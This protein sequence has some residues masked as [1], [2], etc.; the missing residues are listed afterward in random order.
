MQFFRIVGAFV[1]VGLLL[2]IGSGCSSRHQDPAPDVD[3][4]KCYRAG[5]DATFASYA[6]TNH[7][8]C[9]RQISEL[10][11][12]YLQARIDSTPAMID[13]I[14]AALTWMNAGYEAAQG[15]TDLSHQWD[16]YQKWDRA[17]I[18]RK[19]QLDSLYGAIRRQAADGDSFEAQN[20]I[21]EALKGLGRDYLD[22]GDTT[23][24]ASL[25]G[26][27]GQIQYN[28]QQPGSARKYLQLGNE[29]SQEAGRLDF[30]ADCLL[31]L[32][33]LAS[34]HQADFQQAEMYLG[35]ALRNFRQLG[36]H[37]RAIFIQ[38][39]RAY[40]Q[41]QTCRYDR[42]TTYARSALSEA[43]QFGD[44]RSELW[45]THLLAELYLD[46]SLLDSA[47]AFAE[48][49]RQLREEQ[50]RQESTERRL[51]DL[52]HTEST[53]AL[54]LDRQG[55][56]DQALE[57]HEQS[58][59]LFTQANDSSG[60]GLALGRQ[61]WSHLRGGRFVAAETNFARN[62]AVATKFE[63]RL[64]AI[65]GLAVSAYLQDDLDLAQHHLERGLAQ[66]EHARSL[67]SLAELRAGILADKVEL[68]DLQALIHF[69][70]Y[71][72]GGRP[73]QLDSALTIIE[74]RQARTLAESLSGPPPAVNP[75][76]SALLDSLSRIHG[77]LALVSENNEV[78]EAIA[79][80]LQDS[81]MQLRLADSSAARSSRGEIRVGLPMG[82][83]SEILGEHG[84]M[85]AYVLSDWGGFVV[86]AETDSMTALALPMPY[87]SIRTMG[88]RYHAAISR[89]PQVAGFES[90]LD[91]SLA[92]QLRQALVPD[93]LMERFADRH[94]TILPTKILHHLPF[95]TL[96]D[97]DGSYLAESM[98]ISYA[99]S[100]AA[101]LAIRKSEP[102]GKQGSTVV[103]MGDPE[104]GRESGIAGLEFAA[105][106][107]L[108]VSEVLGP[109]HVISITK[110]EAC[111]ER[112]KTIDFTD[113][114]GWHLATHGISDPGDASRSAILLSATENDPGSGWLRGYEISQM[115]LPIDFAFLSA[116]ESG[117][118]EYLPGEGVLSL[119]RSFLLAGCRAVVITG[120]KVDDRASVGFVR[121]FYESLHKGAT[122]ATSLTMAQREYINSARPLYRHPYFWATYRVVGVGF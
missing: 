59:R 66:V 39:Q 65:Y 28:W 1:V 8:P 48:K 86:V 80:N 4:L 98:A 77:R 2:A 30:Q 18:V 78:L 75:D 29:L 36:N 82:W 47:Y 41:Q 58:C 62:L 112:L 57:R 115:H 21:A 16:K 52:A 113:V 81:L 72:A 64:N 51:S 107:I 108:C 68:Y 37:R 22:L 93:R 87:D 42:A 25:F 106:E 83:R 100:V 111:R 118:G 7:W 110:G 61:A 88:Q 35:Q 33:H 103:A 26:Y 122:V 34:V 120:W 53:I 24:A 89:R 44:V 50:V 19:R 92:V 117:Q 69:R 114:S 40:N 79:F 56:H 76:H 90:G 5:D 3:I 54:I 85:L 17:E 105:S 11:H 99:P 94:V 60:L 70:R 10:L 49:A 95:G 46:R 102:Q 91:D 31:Y 74:Q 27:L 71:Q 97:D 23:S 32:A 6:R 9:R 20:E 73:T 63:T 121:R 116:C 43:Q 14:A 12:D 45:C 104:I 109:E 101:L 55:K 84:V 96:M 15:L 38:T 13:T 67:P 119:S